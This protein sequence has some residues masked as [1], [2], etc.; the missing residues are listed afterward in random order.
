MKS[1]FFAILLGVLALLFTRRAGAEEIVDLYTVGPGSDTFSNYGHSALCV[2]DATRPSGI[3]FD[4]G[5]SDTNDMSSVVWDTIRGRPR[6]IPISVDL[7]ILVATFKGQE[8]NIWKQRLP[9][10]PAEAD[11]LAASL[12]RAVLDKKPY[13]YEPAY[14]NCTTQLRDLL[15]AASGGKLHQA[16]TPAPSTP[17]FR[18]LMEQGFSG[19]VLELAGVAL[20]V[21]WPGEARPT[22][23]ELMFLPIRLRD[24]VE[25]LYGAKPEVVHAPGGFFLP[26]ST[27]AGRAFLV[28]IGL[29]LG[30]AVF[31]GSRST[32]KKL[33]VALWVIGIVFGLL[34]LS[35][36]FMALTCAYPW[37]THNLVLL[38]L[39]PTDL[40]LGTLR[41]PRL[42]RY[43]A[44]RLALVAA[45]L[46]LSR[47]CSVSRSSRLRSSPRFPSGWRSSPPAQRPCQRRPDLCQL[48]QRK[49]DKTG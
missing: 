33:R 30:G 8:R 35:V 27:I 5:I 37:V 22:G 6:F 4:F 19:R 26:T 45:A 3:C 12:D 31:A 17:N 38:V 29:V 16:P 13:S 44:A 21:G 23:Y 7:P 18:E 14:A 40:A 36:E 28:I 43:L 15:D 48:A 2:T 25:A 1:R 47:S 34:A 24:T 32:G 20:F 39:L 46:A 42:T 49:P 10:A 41:G 11:A 9:L